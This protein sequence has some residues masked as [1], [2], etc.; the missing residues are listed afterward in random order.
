MEENKEEITEEKK[1]KCDCKKCSLIG[2]IFIFIFLFFAIGL[3]LL[4]VYVKSMDK[5]SKVSSIDTNQEIKEEIINNEQYEKFKEY[6]DKYENENM[7]WFIK[8]MLDKE[9]STGAFTSSAKI[10]DEDYLIIEDG[11]LYYKPNK[12][13]KESYLKYSPDKINDKGMIE[14]KNI[15]L[16][17]TP[18]FERNIKYIIVPFEDPSYVIA[19]DEEGYPYVNLNKMVRYADGEVYAST[20]ESFSEYKFNHYFK[21]GSYNYNEEKP[22]Q[23]VIDICIVNE[24]IEE[25]TDIYFMLEDG[26]LVDSLGNPY[27]EYGSA[28]ADE[29]K[30]NARIDDIGP[31]HFKSLNYKGKMYVELNVEDDTSEI[32]AGKYVLLGIDDNIKKIDVNREDGRIRDFFILTEKGDVYSYVGFY[33]YPSNPYYQL[34]CIGQDAKDIKDTDGSFVAID[35]NGKEHKISDLLYADGE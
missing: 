11:K 7:K 25:L 9:G 14:V 8:D 30:N 1:C 29:L 34:Y 32:P 10:F 13:Q 33:M 4:A 18:S 21:N 5:T 12:K 22:V 17:D 15:T 20:V 6:Y 16:N 28:F 26:S 35:S 3:G 27:V 31:L 2:L 23:K 24:E 19:L